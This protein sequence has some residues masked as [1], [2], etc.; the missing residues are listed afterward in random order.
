MIVTYHI[1]VL[2]FTL[3]LTGIDKHF[4]VAQ[5]KKRYTALSVH[6]SHILL[7]VMKNLLFIITSIY[8]HA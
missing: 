5:G 2:E 3:P 8:L 6:L 4:N 7:F 1:T